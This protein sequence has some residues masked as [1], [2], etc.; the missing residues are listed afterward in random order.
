MLPSFRGRLPHRLQVHAG[1]AIKNE[2]R[3]FVDLE[4]NEGLDLEVVPTVDE[5]VLHIVLC[6]RLN[7]IPEITI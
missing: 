4:L 6:E 3:L 7:R 2:Q 5:T 1:L